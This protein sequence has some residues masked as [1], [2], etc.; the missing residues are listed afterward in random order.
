MLDMEKIVVGAMSGH[1]ENMAFSG[2][3]EFRVVS[4]GGILKDAGSSALS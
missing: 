2:K 1:E 4:I 3:A